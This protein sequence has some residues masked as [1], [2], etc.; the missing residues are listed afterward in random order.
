MKLMP[1]DDAR[2]AM[3]AEIV[4]LPGETVAL[5]AAIGRV[6]AEDVT[7]VRHQPPFDASA[8]DGWAV[9]GPGP[10]RVVGSLLPGQ[11]SW[12]D[13]P[14]GSAVALTTGMPLPPETQAVVRD[15]D[16]SVT[17]GML[18]AALPEAGRDC[19]RRGEEFRLG[20]CLVSAGTLV[21]PAVLGLAAAAGAP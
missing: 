21:T 8:M 5:K 4:A 13:L 20:E 9:H 6:L 17:D 18:H 16:G 15:E 12:T 3:L 11:A 19:R 10:W 14:S 7:A 2:A 1:V